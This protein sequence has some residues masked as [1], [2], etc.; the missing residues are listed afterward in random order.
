[1]FSVGD[2]QYLLRALGLNQVVLFLGAGFSM[3][4]SNSLGEHLPSGKELAK[5]LWQF[6]GYKEEFPES[7]QIS[8]IYEAVLSKGIPQNQIKQFLEANLLCTEIPK[9]YDAI[10]LVYWYRIYTTNV[11]NLLEVIYSR[12]DRPRLTISSYPQG[13][14]LERDQTLDYLQAVHLNGRL[15]CTPREITF[16]VSQF[17]NRAN[18]HDP[19]YE[20]FVGDY[21]T[22][23]TVFIGTD[24]NEPLFWQ[25]VEARAARKSGIAE[26][27]PGSFLISPNISAA[28]CD[29]LKGF[30]ITPVVGTTDDF[31][32]WLADSSAKLPS[33]ENILRTKLPG[34]I[35][36][37]ENAKG[38]KR[39][40]E[41]LKRFGTVFHHVPLELRSQ[42]ERSLYLLGAS[43]RWED[44]LA[45][46]DAPRDITET[47]ISS[48]EESLV[49]KQ[50]LTTIALLGSAG[51]GKSTI[52]RR[53]ALRLAQKAI[54]VFLTN[55]ETLPKAD[56]IARALETIDQRV[57]LLFD[58]AETILGMLPAAT[59][60]LTTITHPPVLVVASRTNDFDRQ[61][62][63]LANAGEV[64]QLFV[65]HLNRREIER[66]IAVLEHNRVLGKLSGMTTQQRIEAFEQ[67]ANK[68]ILVAMRE[69]TTGHGFDEI[70]ENEFA[71]L[72]S[73]ETK[74]LYLCTALATEAGFRLTKQE[75]V[76]CSVLSPAE[77]QELLQ[78]NLHDIV[79]ATG[80]DNDLLLLRHR[81][82]AEYMVNRAAPRDI[83]KESYVR[84]LRVLSSEIRGKARR[85]RTFALYRTLINHYSIFRRFE[86]NIDQARS[87]YD[88]L[89]EYLTNDPQFLLQYGS[90]EL[91][92]GNLQFAENYINQAD[93]L[94]PDNIFI[95]NA[96]GHLLLAEG[97][98]AKNRSEAI[99]LRDQGSGI[100]IAN[101]ENP[102]V[103][104]A[105]CYH[106]YCSK[107]LAWL[108]KW[109]NSH[110]DRANE[111]ENLREVAHKALR[112]FPRDRRIQE[113]ASRIDRV[114]LSVAV[115]N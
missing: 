70:I 52:L 31:L 39:F 94:D 49:N 74:V 88:S 63:R 6:A 44:I 43:P 10:T 64:M 1:M 11:D 96:K 77:S 42:N 82:I 89:A 80:P 35:E 105:Y 79:F 91:E 85:S 71:G 4:A 76:R 78:R 97:I 93:S 66:V 24:L 67:R 40:V 109:G 61:V 33:R 36:I 28:K 47:L 90:L 37:L 15:P 101:M 25:Y 83:L 26:Q 92:V 56:V 87:I 7:T 45:N 32:N 107:R 99:E 102:E 41:D 68:Q 57:I 30:N 86:E 34:L 75:F 98:I 72:A 8:E 95:L 23:P 84:V 60:Q 112:L 14:L 62:T 104:D 2:E 110:D 73:Q 22:L 46:R 114:Y 50:R 108:E 53:L 58:N 17:A 48:V 106:I 21:A 69:A 111:L 9:K 65:P 3:G 55:S 113:I 16:S 27:R 81:S 18:P 115:K 59:K 12:I 100:L 5:R 19:L 13:N 29:I 20:S 38:S 51:C 103:E 54:P